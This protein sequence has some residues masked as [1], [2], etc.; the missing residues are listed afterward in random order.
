MSLA[1]VVC[2]LLEALIDRKTQPPRVWLAAALAAAG[3]GALEVGGPVGAAPGD[4]IGLAQAAFFGMVRRRPPPPPP[5]P[6]RPL[7]LPPPLRRASSAW[8]V[9]GACTAALPAPPPICVRR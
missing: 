8:S 1:V 7:T 6:P 3:V 9:R 2:P 5:P 4:V